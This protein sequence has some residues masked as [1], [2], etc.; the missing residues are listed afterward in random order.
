VAPLGAVVICR[1]PQMLHPLVRG[2]LS[3]VAERLQ[4]TPFRLY[5][6]HRGAARQLAGKRKGASKA[7]MWASR[8]NYGLAAD[9]VGR[10]NGRW[11]WADDLPWHLVGEAARAE[12]LGWGGDWGGP[13]KGWDKPHC[14]WT[15]PNHVALDPATWGD[16]S[17]AAA[18][19]WY[20]WTKRVLA[21]ATD[22]RESLNVCARA[23]QY[24]IRALE[25]G[26]SVHADGIWGP[27]S[28]NGAKRHGVTTEGPAGV[29]TWQALAVQLL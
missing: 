29:T 9:F 24:V 4:P 11:S 25:G 15:G 7:S 19:E 20:G 16:W 8:H 5:E 3:R 23:C 26:G 12:G 21:E 28:R 13:G 18:D 17:D 27:I 22:S 1:D 6:T 14:E 10:V 2:A